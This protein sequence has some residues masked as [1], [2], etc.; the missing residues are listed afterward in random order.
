MNRKLVA[1]YFGAL[2]SALS[3]NQLI[4][5]TATLDFEGLFPQIDA[6]RAELDFPDPDDSFSLTGSWREDGFVMDYFASD[7]FSFWPDGWVDGTLQFHDGRGIGNGSQFDR[8]TFR[9]KDGSAFSLSSF[10]VTE[11]FSATFAQVRVENIALGNDAEPEARYPVFE[12]GYVAVSPLLITGERSDGSTTELFVD[13]ARGSTTLAFGGTGGGNL[14]PIEDRLFD[15]SDFGT[16]FDGVT[17]LTFSIISNPPQVVLE[18]TALE[19]LGPLHP[20]F[21]SENITSSGSNEFAFES[22]DFVGEF[23]FSFGSVRNDGLKVEID[24]ISFDV[25]PLPPVAPLLG[26]AVILLY[27][28]GRRPCKR[29]LPPKYR[30][31]WSDSRHRSAP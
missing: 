2:I 29:R 8:V 12:S 20:V 5:G 13:L 25:I 10:E 3:G 1:I 11:L 7:V 9:R 18:D 22:G 19:I 21:A 31:R 26:S 30:D 14:L 28:A 23:S 17:K 6:E 15:I 4:A 24:N 27:V 16:L